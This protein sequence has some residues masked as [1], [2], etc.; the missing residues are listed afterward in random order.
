MENEVL[1]DVMLTATILIPILAALVEVLKKAVKLPKNL[2]PLISVVLGL[3][4]GVVSYKF[5]DLDLVLRLWAGAFAGLAGTGLFE[6]LKTRIGT[7]K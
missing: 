1:Q 6:A 4:L 2:L 7:T 3:I 5:T